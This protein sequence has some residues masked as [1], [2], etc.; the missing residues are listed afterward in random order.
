MS[1][2]DERC[3]LL[4]TAGGRWW[5]V[6]PG[7][8]V[9]LGRDPG[10]DLTITGR[11]VSRLHATILWP[12]ARPAPQVRDEGSANGSWLDGRSLGREPVALSHG[13]TLELGEDE[14]ARLK[15][16]L[17]VRGAPPA[18]LAGLA[19]GG[20]A[21]GKLGKDCSPLE[22][23]RHLERGQ[24]TARAEITCPDGVVSVTTRQGRITSV[25]GWGAEG[26]V[27][28]DRLV[29]MSQGTFAVVQ[30]PG[31]PPTGSGLE[32][33]FSTYLSKRTA[34]RGSPPARVSGPP[35]ERLQ[36]PA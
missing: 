31:D 12:A 35:T 3:A 32:V 36:R 8:E 20:E 18:S 7:S 15:V 14:A 11:G 16:T 28:L 27:V 34:G 13:S 9:R 17:E 33:P 10:C 19:G 5:L 1:T 24:H 21:R 22:L 30:L 6:R 2:S 4:Q 23:L 25:R 29:P 26:E